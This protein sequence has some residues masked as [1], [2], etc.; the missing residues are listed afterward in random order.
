MTRS[1]RSNARNETPG[2]GAVLALSATRFLTG[3]AT[4]AMLAAIIAPAD[5]TVTIVSG[6]DFGGRVKVSG[7]QLQAAT[8]LSAAATGTAKFRAVSPDGRDAVEKTFDLIL[9]A[10][11]GGGGGGQQISLPA[12]VVNLAAFGD[13]YT[14][15]TGASG[16]AQRYINIVAASIA[17][18]IVLN[19]AISGTVL[20]NS[21][22]A[23]GAPMANNGRD[24]F[25]GAL[26]GAAAQRETLVI[27]Y[28]Y[29]DARYVASPSTFNVQQFENDYRE[30]LD[31]L[32]AAGYRR[33][34]IIL[35]TPWWISDV[36]LTTG[37]SGFS[38]QT[39]SGFEAYVSVVK[40]LAA[41]Y[42]TY[43][44]DAYAAMRDGGGASLIGSDNIHPNDAGHAVIANCVL[45]AKRAG[46]ISVGTTPWLSD[47]MTDA[48]G[49]LLTAHNGE[50]GSSWALQTGYSP[51]SPAQISGNRM[52]SPSS[53]SVYR[54]LQAAPSADYDVEAVLAFAGAISN[55]DRGIMARADAASNTFYF[56]R[57]SSAAGGW[58]LFKTVAGTSTQLGATISGSFSA[59]A[60]LLR[61]RVS[62]STIQAY[63]NNALI[64]SATDADISAPGFPGIRFNGTGQTATTGIHLDSIKAMPIAA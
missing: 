56:A 47:T 9:A 38:G 22:D 28:G 3:T 46:T 2:G 21:F 18:G 43:L 31:G 33:D 54:S 42:D 23:G 13:S 39:R 64:I 29:N 49:V 7:R 48:D 17:G 34:R 58:Q 59:G 25:A 36:G 51:A 4:D 57:F 27:A 1:L 61:L 50:T 45:A 12:S 44:A 5:W 55:N 52:I 11:S 41:Q 30:V 53:L 15:G 40:S 6:S 16:A 8:A 20:Q 63:L 19:Q 62:G 60:N 14:Q 32:L 37:S 24:R 26:T 35:V 10:A